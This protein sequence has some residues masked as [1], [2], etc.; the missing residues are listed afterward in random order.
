[1][2]FR[3]SWLPGCAFVGLGLVLGSC[4]SDAKHTNDDSGTAGSGASSSGSSSSASGGAAGRTASGGSSGA[5]TTGGR[6]GTASGG[7]AGSTQASGGAGSPNGGTG[8]TV[9]AVIDCSTSSAPLNCTG[10][11][12]CCPTS[13]GQN[14]CAKSCGAAVTLGCDSASDCGGRPCCFY[15]R[16]IGTHCA[17]GSTC[18]SASNPVCSAD[19]CP[20]G[21]YACCTTT[22]VSSVAVRFCTRIAGNCF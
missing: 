2:S 13:G 14:Q 12:V 16:T 4:G 9:T 15:D 17:T 11:N 5:S 10:G 20:A 22:G 3:A 7:N 1:M 19:L 21:Q 6:P 18:D 8:P